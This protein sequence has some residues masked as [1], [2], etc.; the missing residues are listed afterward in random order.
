MSFSTL[1]FSKKGGAH[2]NRTYFQLNDVTIGIYTNWYDWQQITNN[3]TGANSSLLWYWNVLGTGPY[4]EATDDFS[5]FHS[6]AKWSAA[7]V[8]QFGQQVPVCG[9][10]VNRD[11][12]DTSLS[13]V[14]ATSTGRI[15]DKRPFVGG[16][17]NTE[18]S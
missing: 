3:W 2:P 12:F 6:F 1:L 17:I 13:A 15:V 7:G 5:D 16:F 18:R 10:N 8:K 11:I 4:G 14:T 9:V